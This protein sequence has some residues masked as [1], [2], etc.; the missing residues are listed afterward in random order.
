MEAVPQPAPLVLEACLTEYRE[1]L[2]KA[3]ARLANSPTIWQM[4]GASRLDELFR[5]PVE[6]LEGA[7]V[8]EDWSALCGCVMLSSRQ[9]HA[10]V[11]TARMVWRLAGAAH[12]LPFALAMMLDA[13][14]ASGQIALTHD[15]LVDYGG[16]PELRS[17]CAAA[18]ADAYA[19]ILAIVEVQA[20]RSGLLASL[21]AYLLPD[22]PAPLE[23]ALAR[24]GE[25]ATSHGA[26]PQ[27]LTGC[28][29]TQAQLASLLQGFGRIW[30]RYDSAR[31]LLL[32]MV[33][34][35][36]PASLTLSLALKRAQ[37]DHYQE[38]RRGYFELARAHDSVEA[39][40]ALVERFGDKD[41]RLQL[42]PFA[43][44]WPRLAIRL[45]AERVLAGA[46]AGLREWLERFAASQRAALAAAQAS[47]AE[48][49]RPLL[50]AVAGK[51]GS[52]RVQASESDLPDWLR[53]PPWRARKR[54]P[55]TAYPALVAHEVAPQ[56]HWQEGERARWQ[57]GFS[58]ASMRVN[59]RFAEL[60]GLDGDALLAATLRLF[61]VPDALHAQALAGERLPAGALGG[62]RTL[63]SPVLMLLPPLAARSLLWAWGPDPWYHME[64]SQLESVVAWLDG[65]AAP[66]V[67]DFPAQ[68]L[69]RG[70]Q[71]AQPLDSARVAAAA[72]NAL[73]T[74]KKSK[75]LAQTWL[76][77]H[78][79]V[80]ADALLPLLAERKGGEDA[81]FALRWLLANGREAAVEAAAAGYGAAGHAALAA[82]R[83]FDPLDLAPARLPKLPPF[84]L[85]ASFA[86]PVLCDGRLLPPAVL[87]AIGEMLAFSPLEPRYA[88]LDALRA[89]CTPESLGAFAWDLFQAW[90]TAGAPA[91]EAW[92]FSALAHL[93]DD[94]CARRLAK[95]IRGWP[96]EGASG[97]AANGLDVLAAMESDLALM[98]LHG[99]AQRV[100][101]KPLQEK[102]RAKLEQLALV[103]GLSP[104]ELADRLVP[105]LGLDESGTLRL[106]FGP[107]QFN[108]GFDEH[109]KPQVRD[110]SGAVL[111]DL[112]APLKSDDTALA[113]AAVA[114]FKALKKDARTLASQQLARLEDA[115]VRRR[116]WNAVEFR[117]FFVEHPLLRHLVRR[118]LWVRCED[119]IPAQCFRVAEDLSYADAN[120]DLLV[121]ADEAQIALVHPLEL[122]PADAAAFG[123]IFADYEI[124]QPFAQL[125]RETWR[126][127][128]E[129]QQSFELARFAGRKVV[130]ASLF[131]LDARGWQRE[132]SGDGGWV[133][134]YLRPLG[135]EFEACLVVN[136]GHIIGDPKTEPV[137]TIESLSLRRPGSWDDSARRRWC[138]LHPVLASEVLRDVERLALAR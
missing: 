89:L 74:S 66:V 129:E 41:A 119:G 58:P 9:Y 40:A 47:A 114:R 51:L 113:E 103:R 135:P 65:L 7:P 23:L 125:G 110:V 5:L 15:S 131:G 87:D 81:G 122:A 22:E 13:V 106:D 108:V 73:R 105:D 117:Q 55:A 82:L 4:L 31:E 20:P 109:L 28:R 137:Q 1:G 16:L 88:G 2:A 100:K 90:L 101:S 14:Q 59:V 36:V 18:D 132:D 136:P 75:A 10:D 26:R 127:D 17:R 29:M 72:A 133:N 93:G 111:K 21:C 50:D 27:F 112:P 126:L 53:S 70:L 107:R 130:T 98:L 138:E 19:R 8:L 12:G 118:L 121:L 54:R 61:G 25:N 43:H 34:L 64:T 24:L 6:W 91:K 68:S 115:M 45:A 63:A 95:L 94:E 99:I 35:G 116:R 124:L 97:R 39:L 46:D 96:S 48:P 37:Q 30:L 134:T 57:G 83:A 38:Q 80:A 60:Q 92:A 123:Q 49:I 79:A 77:R 78:A 33:R 104:E 84:W 120:D 11:L 52:E 85:P 102:A 42:D 128:A 86:R 32:N 71:L 67:E 69:E 56:F 44:T 62:K 76:L 3:R